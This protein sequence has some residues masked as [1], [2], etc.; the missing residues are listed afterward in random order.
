M[1][2]KPYLQVIGPGGDD[3]VKAWGSKLI[4]VKLVDR[5][6]DESDEAIF[7]FTR[8]LP[9]MPIPGEGTPY[10]VRVGWSADKVAV[11]GHYTFQRTHIQGNPKQGQQLQLIC[12][13]G[14]F[15]EHLKRVDSEHFDENTGHKTLGDVFRS[16]FKATGKPVEVSPQ[17]D[18]LPIPGGYSLRWNQSPIDFAADLARNNGAIVKPMGDKMIVMKPGSGESVSGQTLGSLTIRFQD[19]YEFDVELEPRFQY[20][21]VSS[22]YLDTDKGTLEREDKDSGTKGSRD[23]LPHPAPSKDAAKA[24]AEAVA[25]EWG[26]FSGTGMFTIPGEPAAVALAPVTFEG[27]GTP[28]DDQKWLAKTVTHDIIPGVG[29]TT[30]IETEANP[31]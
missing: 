1:Y 24:V 11:T 2:R 21:Q 17:I 4:G 15:I 27:F 13:A 29:W 6:G 19:D 23:A 25:Q 22:S 31:D 14:D 18:K 9:Y 30:T 16:L 12:R 5:D 8:K 10:I 7:I 28:I 3:M 26:K 20:K